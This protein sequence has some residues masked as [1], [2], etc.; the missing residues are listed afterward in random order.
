MSSPRPAFPL[1]L[2]FPLILALGRSVDPADAVHAQCE[3]SELLAFDGLPGD[4]YGTALAAA[5]HLALVGVP[6]SSPSGPESGAAYL[7]ERW[8]GNWQ[9]GAKFE[10]S[11]ADPFDRFGYAVDTDGTRAAVG[12]PRHG[13]TGFGIGAGAV[14]VYETS[15][16]GWAEADKVWASN[17]EALDEFGV[18][19][20]IE[21]D[22]LLVGAFLA[23]GGASESGAVYVYDRTP[24][25]WVESG[26][27]QAL[28]PT[29][30]KSFGFTVALAGDQALI[31]APNDGQ[32]G[33]GAGAAYVF[34]RTP[35]GWVQAA[36]LLPPD[37]VIL[38]Q[39]GYSVALSGDVALAGARQH[40][41]LGLSA[42][43]V[44]VFENGPG[45]WSGV[46]TLHG[47]DTKLGDNFGHSVAFAGEALVVGAPR[48]DALGQDSG[49]VYLFENGPGGWAE[50]AVLPAA[51][52]R[53][54]PR[55]PSAAGSTRSAPPA[56]P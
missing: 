10:P 20:A 52:G 48:S 18:D 33:I 4:Q 37:G 23:N 16:G 15:P 55:R 46:Q 17:G 35:S 56:S 7:F 53:R 6:Y 50:S 38:A 9:L 30:N 19:V 44:Y 12:A 24:S 11:D 8:G 54:C 14:Y 42:G 3:L 26:V 47:S 25:G 2:L 36:K 51:D 43:A 39:M 13:A 40:A 34:E 27:L 29:P 5:G 32:G 31:G 41:V 21:G 45:G 28:D 1:L 49:A 22:T